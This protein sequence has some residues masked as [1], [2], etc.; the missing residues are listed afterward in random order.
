MGPIV[1]PKARTTFRPHSLSPPNNTRWSQFG[2]F[3]SHS[4]QA[5]SGPLSIPHLL[6]YD[7]RHHLGKSATAPDDARLNIATL[8]ARRHCGDTH[9]NPTSAR[10]GGCS[11]ILSEERG[12]K[13]SGRIG[14]T[15]LNCGAT[16]AGIALTRR[17]SKSSQACSG[18]RDHQRP[19]QHSTSL[20]DAAHP[21]RAPPDLE[22][23]QHIEKWSALGDRARHYKSSTRTAAFAH[24]ASSHIPLPA[25]VSRAAGAPFN[26]RPTPLLWPN[27]WQPRG[28][29]QRM[30]STVLHIG[31]PHHKQCLHGIS[32]PIHS[33]RTWECPISP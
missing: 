4:P 7:A 14:C 19:S 1:R 28:T 2:P 16:Y 12:S 18:I 27:Q 26:S 6:L 13:Y 8:D 22:H 25:V 10:R 32:N 5:S 33:T 9:A 3:T 15:P 29:C 17:Q 30:V 24:Q 11:V 31:C 21:V 20:W 23:L